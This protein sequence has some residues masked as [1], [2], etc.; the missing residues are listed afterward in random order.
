MLERSEPIR[1]RAVIAGL[2]L[3]LAAPAIRRAKA[4][5]ALTLGYTATLGFA[6]AFIAKEK[7][8]FARRGL[9]VRLEL[10]TLNSTIP[11][12]LMGQSIQI[13]GPTPTVLLQAN[14]GGLDLVVVSG[15]SGVDPNNKTDGLMV[16]K[17]VAIT[18]PSDC[19]GKRIG[20]PGLNAIYHVLVRKW[21]DDHAVDWRRVNFVEVPFTQSADVLRSGSVDA[22]ATGQP[23]SER[24]LADGIG[25][26]LVT[27]AAIAPNSPPSISYVVTR[28]WA[29]ANLETAHAFRDAIAE[30]VAFQASNP[31]A[32]TES[33]G[34]YIKLPATML[35]MLSP[36][37][38]QATA[39]A[40]QMAFWVDV[41]TKQNMLQA[42]PDLSKLVLP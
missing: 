24:I 27:Y 6:G 34:K 4:A 21:L 13:G 16:R 11:G 35:A 40:E 8:L 39:S 31:G 2:G 17:G 28:E 23:F 12:A 29:T 30:A 25:T 42:P 22:I 10:I 36:P 14:D 33:A 18:Q 20:V 1:R 15:C 38:L 5:A 3:A 32:A 26:L 9:D 19:I 37:L 7:G 41:M